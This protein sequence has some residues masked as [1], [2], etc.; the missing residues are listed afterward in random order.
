MPGLAVGRVCVAAVLTRSLTGSGLLTLRGVVLVLTTS[1]L[2]GQRRDN[3]CGGMAVTQL[4][5]GQDKIWPDIEPAT[6]TTK[7]KAIE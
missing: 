1:N 2:G 4:C 7:N 6:V 5:M 3:G